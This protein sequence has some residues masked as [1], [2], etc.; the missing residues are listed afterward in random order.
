MV[1][2]INN[3]KLKHGEETN[4]LGWFSTPK[5]KYVSDEDDA[6]YRNASEQALLKISLNRKWKFLHRK[7]NLIT[8]LEDLVYQYRNYYTNLS[9]QFIYEEQNLDKFDNVPFKEV[10]Y[11]LET[12]KKFLENLLYK[13][14]NNES[15]SQ[16][17]A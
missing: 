8:D 12:A 7:D 16:P 11:S 3:L 15:D 4:D 2:N 10:D 6:I 5:P 17:E 14:N 13:R 9:V 1:E